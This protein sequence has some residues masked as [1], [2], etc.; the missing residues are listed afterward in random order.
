MRGVPGNPS[1]PP[2]AFHPHLLIE[3]LFPLQSRSRISTAIAITS[4]GPTGGVRVPGP[5]V[6]WLYV[7][8]QGTLYAHT[9]R[10][11]HIKGSHYAE[12]IFCDISTCTPTPRPG[13]GL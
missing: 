1:V 7:G 11:V 2:V 4:P 6:Y 9:L 3:V 8:P 12:Q 5:G 10:R 13:P